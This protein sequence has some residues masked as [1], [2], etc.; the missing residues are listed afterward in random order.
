MSHGYE[1]RQLPDGG[2]EFVLDDPVLTCLVID[3]RVTLRFA[4]TDVVIAEPFDLEVDGVARH[5]D[6][7]RQDT[8][9]PILAT[10]PGTVRWIWAS[11]GGE[12]TIVFMQGQRLVAPGPS[13]RSA[14]S[15]GGV[16]GTRATPIP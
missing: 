3:D 16:D 1:L 11:P 13:V 8:L 10:Y 6:P 14:W 9:G 4:R 5:L 12:L 15:V 2:L 7:H